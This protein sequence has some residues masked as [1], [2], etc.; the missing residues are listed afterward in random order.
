M[1]PD[2]P[3]A[4]APVDRAWGPLGEGE[5]LLFEGTARGRPPLAATLPIHVMILL[6]PFLLGGLLLLLTWKGMERP[7][8][9]VEWTSIRISEKR[10]NGSSSA[11]VPGPLWSPF[12]IDVGLSSVPVPWVVLVL[13]GALLVEGLRVVRWRS[14]EM[15]ITTRRLLTVHGVVRRVR[16]AVGR[17]GEEA[18]EG[19]V[20]VGLAGDEAVALPG[21]DEGDRRAVL[22]ALARHEPGPVPAPPPPLLNGRRLGGGCLVLA[23]A[24]AVAFQQASATGR[25][26]ATFTRGGL[27]GEELFTVEID[28]PSR[29]GLRVA[30][31]RTEH[32]RPDDRAEVLVEPWGST[33]SGGGT[34]SLPDA[35]LGQRLNAVPLT[36]TR[37]DLD[38]ATWRPARWSPSAQQTCSGGLFRTS[39]RIGVAERGA[40]LDVDHLRLAGTF[41]TVDGRELPFEVDL[42]SPGKVT[43]D[44]SPR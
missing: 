31:W 14:L 41:H 4:P 7:E 44:L 11:G 17:T 9:K 33:W 2:E 10:D 43:R 16:R 22:A 37:I 18:L 1:E 42:S 23:L 20:V 39:L 6:F 30:P 29:G 36:L 25:V 38:G 21:L 27:P 26:T 34:A 5:E 28:S 3:E 12:S 24:L 40:T 13:A 35:P 8:W 19:D 15:A 32:P